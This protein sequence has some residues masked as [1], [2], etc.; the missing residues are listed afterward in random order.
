MMKTGFVYHPDYLK[1]QFEYGHVERPDR[2]EAILTYLTQTKLIDSLER[3]VPDPVPTEW[4]A[5]V[6]LPEYIERVKSTSEQNVYLFDYDTYTNCHSYE[7]AR[8]AAGGGLAAVDAIMEGVVDNAFCAVRPPGHHAEIKQAMGFCLFNNIAITARYIQKKYNLTK[9]LI[10]DWD[11]H[12]GNGTQH[13]FEDDP[14]VFFFSTHQYP[15]YPGTGAAHEIG[16]D[17][18]KGFTL[19]VPMLARSGDREYLAVYYEKLLPA[20]ETFQPDFI[21]ISAG[22]DAHF[23]DPLSHIL[24]TTDCFGEL[25]QLVK[26][27]AANFCQNRLISILEGGYNLQ[28]L[29]ESTALHLQKLME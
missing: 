2:L 5:K 10:I 8:L 23:D 14:T 11:V 7:V 22:F 16:I 29:A 6:H 20:V 9:V 24:V 21:L 1:H 25:S 4:I 28:A 19:N 26:E 3:I 12:H 27:L 18:G 13:I 15:F 17:D